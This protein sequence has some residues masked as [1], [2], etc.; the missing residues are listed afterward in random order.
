[1]E[2]ERCAPQDVG[3]NPNKIKELDNAIDYQLGIVNSVFVVKDGKMAYEKH[4]KDF[5]REDRHNITSLTQGVICAL[6]GIAIEEG[7]IAGVSQKVIDFFPEAAGN[8]SDI[9]KNTLTIENLLTMTTPYIWKAKEPLDRIR[10]QKDW[11]KFMLGNIAKKG[12]GDEFRFNLSSAHILSAILTKATGVSTREYANEHLFRPLGI[13][14]I[15]DQKMK[16]YSKDDIFGKNIKGWIKDPQGYNTG[17]W[18]MEMRAIDLVKL[19]YLFVNGGNFDGKQILTKEWVD[20]VY[21]QHTEDYGYLWWIREDDGVIS[22]MIAGLGGT[23]LYV[24]PSKNIVV[25]I[26]SRVDKVVYDRW[27]IIGD[28]ILPSLQ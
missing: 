25:A 23:Y 8:A 15:E 5:T 2:F 3:M 21:Q 17:G 4:V 7:K 26:L 12:K 10:R 20:K 14:E 1:M 11:T 9:L 27:E 19:G 13:T 6:I 22:Y 18:G 28:Y 16:S 24:I